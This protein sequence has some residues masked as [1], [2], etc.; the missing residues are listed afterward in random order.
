MNDIVVKIAN[1]NI[2]KELQNIGFDSSYSSYAVN[3]YKGATYKIFNLKPHEANILKQ[4][5]L[6]LGFDCAVR[7]ETIMCKCDYT[8]AVIFASDAQISQLIEKLR[9]QPFRLNE[10]AE[11]I[12]RLNSNYQPLKIRKYTFDWSRP[13]IMGI[14]NV[15]PDSF[16]DG[17]NFSN[18]EAAL[19]RAVEMIEQGV[20]IID[21]GGEST[22]PDAE[23]VSVDEELNRVIPVIRKIR[24]SGIG[25]PISIDTRNYQTA[26]EAVEA[27]AD[28]INDVSG[29][30]YDNNLFDYAAKNNI[31]SIIV[32]SNSVPAN[33]SDFTQGDIVE[34]IYFSLYNKIKKLKEAGMDNQ[35]IIADPGIGFGK[36]AESNFEILKRFNEFN[37]LGVPLLLGISRKSF[38][39]KT[40]DITFEEADI[41]TALYSSLI[42]KA[43]IHRVHNVKLV[44]QYLEYADKIN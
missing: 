3:K 26:K 28:I 29:F 36:S 23:I 43:N 40:F 30:E 16:S 27:G 22:R 31:P 18:V 12:N 10:L 4:L 9:L 32:H 13:Y 2:S 17:G 8:D 33:S 7:R 6:S 25:I 41:A 24:E 19:N 44:K 15:T 14:L 38:I 11:L 5:C 39:T 42:K 34:E 1:S 37:T 21:V 20:D 35:N